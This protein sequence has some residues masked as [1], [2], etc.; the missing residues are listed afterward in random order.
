MLLLGTQ[1]QRGFGGPYALNYTVVYDTLDRKGYAGDDFWQML[2]D[3]RVMEAAAL[4]AM[5]TD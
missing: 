1:W 3:L 2:D 5:H 4:D